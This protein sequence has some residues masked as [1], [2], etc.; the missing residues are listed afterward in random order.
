MVTQKEVNRVMGSHNQHLDTQKKYM[1]DYIEPFKNIEGKW[2]EMAM[3]TDV[4]SMANSN[5]LSDFN[6]KRILYFCRAA[7]K[8][9][10]LLDRRDPKGSSNSF[11]Y[12]IFINYTD[13]IN[14]EN[15]ESF[16][17]LGEG[18]KKIV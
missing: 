15:I 1:K 11:T 7:Y 6:H 3:K 5:N 10:I 17:I 14:H 2:V 13:I 4:T 8:R 12:T 9:G 16:E 18:G